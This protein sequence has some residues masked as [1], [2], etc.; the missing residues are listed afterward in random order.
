MREAGQTVM[1]TDVTPGEHALLLAARTLK[2]AMRDN[3][4]ANAAES[5][6][7]WGLDRAREAR[8]SAEATEDIA[9]DSYD[10]ALAILIAPQRGEGD[11]S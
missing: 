9:Q 7:R 1:R 6:A 3:A 5:Q 10:S 2:A 11:C 8:M 4:A